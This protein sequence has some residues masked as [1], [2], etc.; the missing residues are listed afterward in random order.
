MWRRAR[1][2]APRCRR[3]GSDHRRRHGGSRIR[4]RLRAPS[5]HAPPRCAA[6]DGPRCAARGSSPRR[7]RWPEPG[8][9]A[10]G[11]GDP[12]ARPRPRPGSGRSICSLSGA[13]PRAVRRSAP[14]PTPPDGVRLSACAHGQWCGRYGATRRTSCGRSGCVR[15]THPPEVLP[16]SSRH[17]D[18]TATTSW[19]T[20]RAVLASAPQ[21]PG[22]D[23][24]PS[25]FHPLSSVS[26]ADRQRSARVRA[27]RGPH[28]HSTTAG[29]LSGPTPAEEPP[30]TGAPDGPASPR[31]SRAVEPGPAARKPAR[32]PP[33]HGGRG[34]WCRCR[35]TTAAAEPDL[36]TPLSFA[37]DGCT[38]IAR[39]VRGELSAVVG[40]LEGFQRAHH[41]CT[42][43]RWRN[44][45]RQTTRH[46][47]TSPLPL[48]SQRSK[49]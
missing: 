48:S 24:A 5:G 17:A 12:A 44:E 28:A 20:T 3:P 35:P 1:R 22:L 36:K 14:A 23:V 25:T 10:G 45:V 7:P 47:V 32:P 41:R 39:V 27:H 43:E 38:A 30:V 49:N 33:R 40:L 2:A 11:T 15:H 42:N 34:R 6:R 31:R 13:T 29:D 46:R 21:H 18:R 4:A 8:S 19:V 16:C 26:R 37:R 9:G